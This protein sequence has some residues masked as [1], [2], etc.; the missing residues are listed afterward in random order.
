MSE[1]PATTP[2]PEEPFSESP[3]DIVFELRGEQYESWRD[4]RPVTVE[5]LLARAPGLV[6]DED[7][8]VELLY[9]EY[10]LREVCGDA[11]SA[12]E[13]F[14]RLPTHRERLRRLLEL[15]DL[16]E[17]HKQLSNDAVDALTPLMPIPVLYRNDQPP[18]K[19]SREITEQPLIVGRDRAAAVRLNDASISRHHC[20]IWRDGPVCR[21]EDAGSTNGVFVNGERIVGGCELYPGDTIRI[22][23]FLLVVGLRDG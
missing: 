4:G 22:A 17:N 1:T 14:E 8:V 15:H 20:L 7:A 5:E 3:S 18:E 2:P 11:P 12:E 21:L 23:R 10:Q 6:E 9:S 16:I 19:W 13:Y